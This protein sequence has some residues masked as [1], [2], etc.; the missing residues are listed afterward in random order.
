MSASKIST[1]EALTEGAELWIVQNDSQSYWWNE[2]DFRAGFLFS[3]TLPH[4]KMKVPE[5]ITKLL[6]ETALPTY[7]FTE[8]EDLLLI[9]SAQHFHNQWILL[10]ESTPEQLCKKLT[11]MASSLKIKKIRFFLNEDSLTP[12]FDTRLSTSFEQ[13]SYVETP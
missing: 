3:R 10:W 2:L 4:T 5:T 11:V 9:G 1:E 13:I 7:T 6:S 12:L 8:D